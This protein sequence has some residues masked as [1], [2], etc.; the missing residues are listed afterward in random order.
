VNVG[1]AGQGRSGF[2]IHYRWLKEDP[3]KYRIVAVA[4]KKPGRTR[5]V[6]QEQDCRV[7]DDYRKMLKDEEV[8]LFINAL[9]S[10]L[11]PKGTIDAFKAGKNVVCEKPLSTKVSEFDRMVQAGKDAK[12]LFAPFQNSRFYPYFRKVREILDSGVIGEAVYVRMSWSGFARRWDWQTR[13][14]LRGGNLNNTGPHPLDHGVILFGGR[15]PKVFAK[16]VNG[17]GSYGD[18]DD[19]SFVVL[20]GKNAP[21]IEIQLNSYDAFPSPYRCEISATRGGLVASPKEIRWKFYDPKEAPKQRLLPAWSNEREYC[22]ED[23]PW[24]E[25]SWTLDDSDGLTDFERNSRAFYDNV[26]DALV[27]KGKLVVRPA[28]VRRQVAVLEEAHRQNRLP[29]MKSRMKRN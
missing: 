24:Q 5:E 29:K 21:T 25:D 28:E 16:L 2:G 12:K 20:H 8:E 11:H 10:D 1:I 9:P 23:L 26:Y 4:D 22:R 7:Y 19:F 15:K 13:Q 18:A 3:A 14:E 17:P 6:K 27:N